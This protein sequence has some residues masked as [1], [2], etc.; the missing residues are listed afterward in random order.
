MI[1]YGNENSVSDVYREGD[2][3][4]WTILH[5]LRIVKI[6]YTLKLNKIKQNDIQILYQI[7]NDLKNENNIL[8]EKIESKNP[9]IGSWLATTPHSVHMYVVQTF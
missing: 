2:Y 4:I 8:Q 3:M 1:D 7:I 6:K 5:D 9:V